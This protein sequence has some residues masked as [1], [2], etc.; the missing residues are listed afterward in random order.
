MSVLD[1]ILPRFDF[2]VKHLQSYGAMTADA[3]GRFVSIRP[4]HPRHGV[5]LVRLPTNTKPIICLARTYEYR[6]SA[7]VYTGVQS[8]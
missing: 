8:R 5:A 4:T 6:Y 2:L 1:N 3:T 7:S